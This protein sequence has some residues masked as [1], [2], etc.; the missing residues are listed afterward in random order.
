MEELESQLRESVW[1]RLSG[2]KFEAS[3]LHD[4]NSVAY[5][6]GLLKGFLRE[7]IDSGNVAKME[8][9]EDGREGDGK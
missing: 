5:T 8:V 2:H 9:E 3:E 4:M 6:I 1:V 7:K